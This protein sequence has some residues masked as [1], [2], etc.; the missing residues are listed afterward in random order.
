[1]NNLSAIR[2][3]R[4]FDQI[5]WTLAPRS[6]PLQH[7][8]TANLWFSKI[9]LL[10][11]GAFSL[12]WYGGGWPFHPGVFLIVAW[13]ILILVAE[14]FAARREHRYLTSGKS[15]SIRSSEKSSLVTL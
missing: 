2:E 6:L 11:L 13:V 1:M 10:I 8:P 7:V 5:V 14:V 4:N 3:T 12:S 9:L 15:R